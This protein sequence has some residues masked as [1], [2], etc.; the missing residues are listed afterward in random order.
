M[1]GDPAEDRGLDRQKVDEGGGKV[2]PAS[3]QQFYSMSFVS[4]TSHGIQPSIY[5]LESRF[6]I[7]A[8][9]LF[10]NRTLLVLADTIISPFSG[11]SAAGL[12]L[13]AWPANDI[14]AIASVV[15]NTKRMG[16]PQVGIAE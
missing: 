11:L 13:L 7:L 5:V 10:Q 3:E 1:A 14:L 16:Q 9:R 2:S 6:D 8:D 12:P 15:Q 4:S